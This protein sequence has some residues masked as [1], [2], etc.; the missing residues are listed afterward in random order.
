MLQAIRSQHH[1]SISSGSS[2]DKQNGSRYIAPYA[3]EIC[4]VIHPVILCG[5]SGTRLWPLSRPDRPKPFVPLVGERTLFQQTL[6]RVAGAGQYAEPVIVAGPAHI[7]WIEQQAERRPCRLLIEPCA[8]NTAP[9]IALAAAVLS[10]DTIMLVCPSDHY[11]ADPAAFHDAVAKA[12]ELA[13]RGRLVSLGIVP[14]HAETGYGYIQAGDALGQGRAVLRFVEKPD[15]SHAARFVQS[16]QYLWNAGIF[17]MRAGSYLEE[18]ARY[19]SEMAELVQHAVASGRKD[20][21]T[22]F[23]EE[24]S[25]CR[26]TG[27]SID[28]A[29]MENTACAAVVAAN[30]G[31]SDIGNWDAL[32]KARSETGQALVGSPHRQHKCSDVMIRSDGPRVSVLGLNDVVVIADGGEIL[33][34]SRKAAQDVG[35]L[36]SSDKT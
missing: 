2:T 25:F 3:L 18:L 6:D 28:Y 5:G 16:S 11:I 36:A 14:T 26:I 35:T 1:S 23:P 22:V 24:A 34:M 27:E 7:H 20:G 33:V 13:A 9:A 17:V 32:M 15:A 12:A 31:W 8:R 4:I 30:M 29:V 10:P 19:R 21:A